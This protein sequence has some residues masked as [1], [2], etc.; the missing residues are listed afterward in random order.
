[1][2]DVDPGAV[3]LASLNKNYTNYYQPF[4]DFGL[5]FF[6]GSGFLT[7]E[8][9]PSLVQSV[10]DFNQTIFNLIDQINI[11]KLNRT[12]ETAERVAVY[13]IADLFF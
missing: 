4:I 5:Q 2:L 6:N 7:G 12:N 10:L 11:L 9:Y 8:N 3:F 1:M 13:S